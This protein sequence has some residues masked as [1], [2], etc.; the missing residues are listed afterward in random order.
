MHLLRF[1]ILVFKFTLADLIILVEVPNG[2]FF[3]LLLNSSAR[4][5]AINST[6]LKPALKSC[7]ALGIRTF[8]N[9]SNGVYVKNR[10][11]S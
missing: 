8:S 2:R 10:S 1:Q 5:E 9:S 11:K 3:I 7:L 6:V 4:D